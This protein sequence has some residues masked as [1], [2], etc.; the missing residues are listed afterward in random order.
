MN[1]ASIS[2]S[3]ILFVF[4]VVKSSQSLQKEKAGCERFRKLK[5]LFDWYVKREVLIFHNASH[6]KNKASC[7]AC[8]HLN[9]CL[10]DKRVSK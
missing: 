2:E 6:L 5:L 4:A 7:T 10:N 8:A 3:D 1:S 9:E